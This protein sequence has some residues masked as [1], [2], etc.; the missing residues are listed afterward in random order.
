MCSPSLTCMNCSPVLVLQAVAR[1][2]SFV[3]E[4]TGYFMDGR[5][6]CWRRISLQ[7]IGDSTSYS[8]DRKEA[9]SGSPSPE[10]QARAVATMAKL[11]LLWLKLIILCSTVEAVFE[12]QVGK[13]DW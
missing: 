8:P 3:L 13:F 6:Y 7:P 12:D 11:I 1:A 4:E 5:Y 10:E 2:F 9:T